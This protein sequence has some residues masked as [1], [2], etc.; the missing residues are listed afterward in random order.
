MHLQMKGIQNQRNVNKFIENVKVM[1]NVF[2]VMF[3]VQQMFHSKVTTEI[4]YQCYQITEILTLF[5]SS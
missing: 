4:P 3:I 5:I 2:F 1:I